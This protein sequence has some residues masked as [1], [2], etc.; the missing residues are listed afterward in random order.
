M[1]VAVITPYHEISD[2]LMT[3]IKSVQTQT[4][5]DVVHI[6]IGD[7]CEIEKNVSHKNILNISLPRNISDYGD[8]PRSIGVV[9]AKAMKAD[10]IVFLD[11]D[12]W[13]ENNHIK[14]MV[15]A[16]TEKNAYVVACRRNLCHL[17]GRVLGICPQSNGIFLCDTNCL[18]VRKEMFEIASG[19]W[20]I[21][22]DLH[23][24]GDRVIWDR[25]IHATDRIELIDDVTVNYRTAFEGHYKNFNIALP[26]GVKKGSDILAQAS[27]MNRLTQRSIER[28]SALNKVE[29]VES[30][31]FIRLVRP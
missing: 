5:N 17:D 10:A 16:S 21:P 31:G 4:H 30:E 12:N 18:F 7:G 8:S 19:W 24:L 26:E 20:M 9:Y 1:K 14:T 13:Y 29:F 11:S 25:L 23:V 28:C 6:M 2:A 3:C 27:E 15:D 22:D